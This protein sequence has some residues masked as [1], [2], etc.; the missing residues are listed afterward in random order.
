M[1]PTRKW[2][3]KYSRKPLRNWRHFLEVCDA[4]LIDNRSRATRPISQAVEVLDYDLCQTNCG[5][6]MIKFISS[7]SRLQRK[8][9]HMF[10]VH[11]QDSNCSIHEVEFSYYYSYFVGLFVDDASSFTL[12]KVQ[13]RSHSWT[14]CCVVVVFRS[15]SS[16]SLHVPKA[17]VATLFQATG[18]EFL[19]FSTEVLTH[20]A[21]AP[22]QQGVRTLSSLL[23]A[24]NCHAIAWDPENARVVWS[25]DSSNR[26]NRVDILISVRFGSSTCKHRW[27]WGSNWQA[28]THSPKFFFFFWHSRACV[29]PAVQCCRGYC[30]K[31]KHFLRCLRQCS[32][33]HWVWTADHNWC[34]PLFFTLLTTSPQV[35]NVT[36]EQAWNYVC[37]RVPVNFPKIRT[38]SNISKQRRLRP[39]MCW[40]WLNV[41]STLTFDGISQ[42]KQNSP[43]HKL[44]TTTCTVEKLNCSKHLF[45]LQLDMNRNKLY[46]NL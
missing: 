39:W 42:E 31:K 6:T 25:N 45:D 16:R 10:Y 9:C 34:E 44:R 1:V 38:R 2:Q 32:L 21:R 37:Q 15:F 8:H 23:L 41:L 33:L 14:L 40:Q 11:Q 13:V 20:S 28:E 36:T 22:V 27:L 4:D 18:I 35:K 5:K 29:T 12:A 30:K 24:V 43:T 7:F 19:R 3:T 17:L 26:T 46:W